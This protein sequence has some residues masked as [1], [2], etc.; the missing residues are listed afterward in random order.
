MPFNEHHIAI[1]DGV[2][3]KKIA[4]NKSFVKKDY[5]SVLH[6]FI[7]MFKETQRELAKKHFKKSVVAILKSLETI[8]SKNYLSIGTDRKAKDEFERIVQFM[9]QTIVE[10]SLNIEIQELYNKVLGRVFNT[11]N[12]LDLTSLNAKMLSFL[13]SCYGKNCIKDEKVTELKN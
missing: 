4:D 2:F 12:Q 13:I 3:A 11:I 8:D 10:V 7:T 9:T 1:I 6:L 5:F